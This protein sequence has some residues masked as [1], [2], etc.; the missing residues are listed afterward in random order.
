MKKKTIL[1]VGSEGL[2]GQ[3]LH[4][5]LV[6]RYNCI[7]IDIKDKKEKNYYKCD[8][9]KPINFRKILKKINKQDKI[10]AAINTMYPLKHSN[11]LQESNKKFLNFINSHLISYYNFNKEI[12]EL[13]SN[14]KNKKILINLSSIYG[15]KIPNF[16]IY[17]NTN[18]KMPIEYSIVKSGLIAMTKYF[19]KWS[20]FKNKKIDFFSIS[21]AG[22]ESNQSKKF[23]TNY[24]KFYKAKMMRA[25][26]LNKYVKKILNNFDKKYNKNITITGGAKI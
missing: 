1:I 12:Y 3:S 19:E 23:K 21:P 6:E 4:K 18:I 14:S 8:L 22:I 20:K 13:F 10:F 7:R 25:E 11:F 15:E 9:K 2:I 26:F 5:S 24:K 16:N 17:R